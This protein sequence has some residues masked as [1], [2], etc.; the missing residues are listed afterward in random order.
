MID[1]NSRACGWSVSRRQLVSLAGTGAL[2][3]IAGCTGGGSDP[4][5]NESSDDNETDT[6]DD[7]KS[8]EELIAEYR[9]PETGDDYDIVVAQ[10]GSGDY[11]SVQAA[12][13]AIE[14]GTFEGTRVYIK[15]AGT[16]RNWSSPP[17]EPT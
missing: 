3:S 15:E 14:P 12:I 6:E 2:G 17:T 5:S 4:D 1:D 9:C 8:V 13:D 16:R 7:E 10:D 11:E